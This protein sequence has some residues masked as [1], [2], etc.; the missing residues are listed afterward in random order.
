[1]MSV[2]LGAGSLTGSRVAVA[3]FTRIGAGQPIRDDGPE[4]HHTKRGTPTMGGLV[5]IF[6]VVVGYFAA[7]LVTQGEP[8]AS[9]LLLLFLLAGLGVVGFLD[10]YLKVSRQN[11]QGLR[12]QDGRPDGGGAV[13]RRDGAVAWLVDYRGTTPASTS[14]SFLR[15]ITWLALPTILAIVLIVDRHRL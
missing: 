11:N 1:M 6:S 3:V 2:L 12:G 10:D 14:V 7:T 8:S 9:A 5:I 4:S 13:L 15:D